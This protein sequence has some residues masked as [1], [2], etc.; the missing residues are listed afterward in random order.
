MLKLNKESLLV[1]KRSYGSIES[2]T[3]L[4][5]AEVPVVL[6]AD[7]Q[8][9]DSRD[10]R[11]DCDTYIVL[12]MTPRTTSGIDLDVC[13]EKG[14]LWAQAVNA[15]KF[16]QESLIATRLIVKEVGCSLQNSKKRLRLSVL[17]AGWYE[18][19]VRNPTLIRVNWRS[20][21]GRSR[22]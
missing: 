8:Q 13:F 19:S 5:I 20:A 22:S 9:V 2:S 10:V 21:M 1:G 17:L 12:N 4:T 18:S 15:V 7:G 6:Q 16:S 3:T 11:K 14:L